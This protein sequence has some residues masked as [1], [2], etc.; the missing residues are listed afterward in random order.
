MTSK[1]FT[2]YIKKIHKHDVKD[3]FINIVTCTYPRPYR[4]NFLSHLKN[5]LIKIPNIR[6]IVV[7]DNDHEDKELKYFLPDFATLLYFGP[8]KDKGNAQRNY[9]WE[10][11]YDSQLDGIIYNADDDNIYDIR[12]FEEIRKT[13]KFGIMPVGNLPTRDGQTERPLL[14]NNGRFKGWNSYWQRKYS[15]D[16]AGFCFHVNMLDKIKKPFWTH[17]G[18]AGETE[19]ISK[20]IRSPNDMEFLCNQCTETYVWHNLLLD[21]LEVKSDRVINLDTKIDGSRFGRTTGTSDQYNEIKQKIFD[22]TIDQNII[23][24]IEYIFQNTDG[25][26]DSPD[27]SELCMLTNLLMKIPNGNIIE[28]GC[29]RGRTTCVLSSNKKPQHK[30]F[31][32]DH[33]K[34]DNGLHYNPKTKKDNLNKFMT[35]IKNHNLENTFTLI[36]KDST[37]I[38]WSDYVQPESVKLLFYDGDSD[39][40]SIKKS[41]LNIMPCMSSDAIIVFHDA[42]WQGPKSMIEYLCKKYQ[43][44]IKIYIN[45]WEGL[46]VL[47]KI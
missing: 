19:F 2:K 47:S 5:I 38:K 15:T 24:R 28:I 17:H 7:D 21:R 40:L 3:Q 27:R 10:Y 44:K 8:T 18:F 6:W 36:Q 12:L 31:V 1:I 13:H 42:A 30:L 45:I 9:A 41:I 39:F 25:V 26:F 33:F 11:I 34:S 14:D 22:T 23:D 35:T 4:L 20:I 43:F 37:K 16:M 46:A 32:V 29:W